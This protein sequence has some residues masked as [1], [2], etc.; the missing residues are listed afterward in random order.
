MVPLTVDPLD[1][2]L[3]VFGNEYVILERESFSIGKFVVDV[4]NLDEATLESVRGSVIRIRQRLGTALVERDRDGLLNALEQIWPV[5]DRLPVYHELVH[6]R[7]VTGEIPEGPLAAV[8]DETTEDY[9]SLMKW[10]GQLEALPTEVEHFRTLAL[11]FVEGHLSKLEKRTPSAYVAA[12]QGYQ[13]YAGLVAQVAV[14]QWSN[15][16]GDELQRMRKRDREEFAQRTL[17]TSFTLHTTFE[18]APDPKAEG[19]VILAERVLIP[20]LE[21]FLSL[22]L[23]R[24]FGVGH[25]PRRC[26]HCGRYFLLDSGYDIRYC[27]RE[28]PDEPGKTCRQIGA[29]RK[30]REAIGSDEIRH[31]YYTAYNRLKMR[32]NRGTLDP[33]DW[34]RLVSELQDLRDAGYRGEI[35]LAE[36][37]ERF[38]RY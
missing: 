15:L 30:E 7:R 11:E 1:G 22:D 33:N 34:N 16:E 26:A 17:R 36:L 31:E 37:R 6:H 25:I 23:I 8:F 3:A 20:D 18:A 38:Q 12:W 5:A 10:L 29:H 32:K 14:D 35:T 9:Q 28:T 13:T 27:D 4:L 21:T 19:E 2:F 24:G